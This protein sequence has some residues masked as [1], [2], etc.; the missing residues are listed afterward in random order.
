MAIQLFSSL[1]AIIA[2]IIG[3]FG[4]SEGTSVSF[5]GGHY[6]QL[7]PLGEQAAFTV[8]FN[9]RSLQD[10]GVLLI[11]TMK[12]STDYVA[13]V[14]HSGSQLQ[15]LLSQ[16]GHISTLDSVNSTMDFSE[17][18]SFELRLVN[19]TLSTIVQDLLIATHTFA[20]SIEVDSVYF[21]G[22]ES[23]FAHQF[24]EFPLLRYH[25]G[26]MANVTLTSRPLQLDVAGLPGLGAGCC[27]APRYPVW[28]LDTPHTNLTLTFP[29]VTP[30]ADV[31]AMSFRLRLLSAEDG[32]VMLSHTL[33]S[34]W[35]LQ[36]LQGRLQLSVN[37]SGSLHTGYC[38]DSML[39]DSAEWRQVEV[40]LSSARIT[41]SVD[42]L[43]ESTSIFPSLL[44][45]SLFPRLLQLGG[46]SEHVNGRGFV[47]CFQRPRVNGVDIAM[48]L[49]ESGEGTIQPLNIHWNDLSFSTTDLVVTEGSTELLSSSVWIQLPRD[50]FTDD[51]TALYQL[52][53]EN[54]IH[55]EVFL[56]PNYGHVYIGQRAA[57]VESF[58]YR[59]ILSDEPSLQVAYSHDNPD[60][61]TDVVVFRVWAGCEGVVFQEL[62]S[63]FF[64]NVEERD[65][66]LR[67]QHLN[68]LRLAVGTRNVIT[69]DTVTIE[70]QET[71]DPALVV[72]RVQS[73]S[74]LG[75]ECSL[76]VAD[77]CT[78]C[79]EGEEAGEVLMNGVSVKFFHQDDINRGVV[80]FQHFESYSIAPLVIRL[81]VSIEGSTDGM[82]DV[83]IP[84]TLYQGHINLTSNPSSDC[85]F[86]KEDG[87]ALISPKHLSV[88]TNFED[89]HPVI[90][91]D[92]LTL[93]KYGI[94]Q[95]YEAEESEW[96]D[97]TSNSTNLHMQPF[98]GESLPTFFTQ[99]DVND[100]H[101]RYVHSETVSFNDPETFQFRVRS[102]NFSSN[103]TAHLCVNIIP[104]DILFQPSI[105]VHLT[106]LALA[107]GASAQINRTVFNTSLD[108]EGFMYLVVQPE[109]SLQQLD[110]TY[111]L[112]EPPS[113][114][115]LE[116]Q[117][118]ILVAGDVF[119]H[120]DVTSSALVYFHGG[121][122]DHEDQ[123][124]FYGETG[125][126]E[127]LAIRP[128]N[129]TTN[130]TLV[131]DITPVNDHPPV[132]DVNMESIRP[133]E[134]CWVQVTVANINVTD[135]DRPADKLKIFLRK[136]ATT[137]TGIFAFREEPD[138]AIA[139]FYMQ[140]ILDQR[141]IFAHQLNS[142]LNYTQVLR[143]DDTVH[144]IRKPILIAAVPLILE[145]SLSLP[146]DS[147]CFA[148][149][150]A[151]T[152]NLQVRFDS[153]EFTATLCDEFG[154]N[155]E[156]VPA[157]TVTIIVFPAHGRITSPDNATVS[158]FQFHDLSSL[159]YV[160]E[161]QNE[162]GDVLELEFTH[163]HSV[164]VRHTLRICIQPVL[165][166]LG[167]RIIALQVMQ[168][169]IA[170]ITAQHLAV[171]SSRE[172][173]KD[174]LV[175]HV[176]R[177]P[178]YGALLN[179]RSGDPTR[180]L[181]QFT[182]G[183]LTRLNIVYD[184]TSSVLHRQDDI[185]VRVCSPF[186]C[187]PN[188][189]LP[190]GIYSTNL[191]VQ[192]STIHV[193]EGGTYRFQKSDFNVS[194]PP[195]YDINI[196]INEDK[197]PMYGS[198]F[199]QTPF[200]NSSAS[201]FG[202]EDIGK[203]RYS[204]DILENLLD[205]VEISVEAEG[206]G[207]LKFILW[208]VI[209][210][211]NHH[212]PEVVNPIQNLTV[213]QGGTVLINASI[214]SAHD[215]DAGSED[216]DLLWSTLFYSRSGYLFLDTDPGNA[217]QGVRNWKE[218]DVRTNRLYYRNTNSIF[219]YDILV[220]QVSD[221]G[222]NT[223]FQLLILIV[224][225]D[226]RRYPSS[227]FRL[228][229]GGQKRI[230][231]DYLRY[232]TVNDDSL[233][234][235]DFLLTLQHLPAHGQLTLDGV[236]LLPRH[237]FTQEQINSS[238]LL[239]THDH[240]NSIMDSFT[241]IISVPA[242]Q[243][244]SKQETFDIGIDAVDDDPPVAE[245]PARMFVVE[246]QRAEIDNTTFRISD[247]DS[248]TRVASD[249]VVCQ[250]VQPLIHGRLEKLRLGLHIN[251]TE[252]FTKYDLEDGKVWYR[253][254]GLLDQ[255]PDQL[256]FNLTDGI[257]KQPTV[258]NMTIIILPRVVS[259][260][261]SALTVI[262]NKIAVITYEEIM[263][264]HPYLSTV[265][266]IFRIEGSGPIH[267]RLVDTSPES[268]DN[269][270]HSFT[271]Q[272][273]RNK[274]I[275]YY[276]NGDESLRDSFQFVYE[277]LEPPE[278]NRRSDVETFYIDI[279]PVNDQHPVIHGNASLKLW[280]TETVL[281]D[282]NYINI[283]DYDTPPSKLVIIFQ[284][285]TIG[286]YIA[287]ANNTAASIQWFTQADVRARSIRF[288]HVDGPIG[289]IL[290]NVTD[291]EHTESSAIP[292]YADTLALECLTHQWDSIHVDFLG[293]VMV[294]SANL[295]CTTSDGL[296]NRE[297][298]YRI[299]RV[300]LGHFEVNS[301]VRSEFNSTEVSAGAVTFVHTET[302]LWMERERLLVSASS[303]PASP[304][305]GLPLFVEVRYPR[306]PLG[307]QLA[308]NT[309]LNLTEGGNAVIDQSRLDGRNLR[310]AAWMT[311]QSNPPPNIPQTGPP[312]PEDLVVLYQV[313]Q[314]PRHGNLTLGGIRVASFTQRDLASAHLRYT[315]DDSETLTDVV[316]FNVTV[317]L[318]EGVVILH[319]NLETIRIAVVPVNDQPPILQASAL[320][321]SLV[322]N[323]V[324]VLTSLDIE[325]TDD[326]NGPDQVQL[327][328]LS[329]PNNTQI[330]LNGSVLTVNSTITQHYIT[331]Q[332]ISLN[333]FAVGVGSFTF[334]FTDGELASEVDVEFM[335]TVE[336]HFL[337]LVHS[338]EIVSFQN[339]TSGTIIDSNHLD[340]RTNG[341]RHETVFTIVEAPCCGRVM[342]GGMEVNKFT[343]EDIDHAM[344]SYIPGS[345]THEDL[346][347]LNISNHNHSLSVNV[348]IHIV[349][350]GHTNS[351]TDIIE[352]GLDSDPLVQV[353]P[354]GVLLLDELKAF[355]SSIPTIK[356]LQTPTYGHLEMRVPLPEVSG[357]GKRATD[358]ISEFRYDELQQGWIVYVWDYSKEVSGDVVTD[359]FEVLVRAKGVLPGRAVITI[360]LYPP[361]SI[362]LT[363]D[364]GHS[365]S[366]SDMG[367]LSTEQHTS[368]ENENG[369]PVYTLVPI[370]GI[371]LFLLLLI[372]VVVAF[373]LTQQ[374][375]I[376]KKW[377][378]TISPHHHHHP[379]WSTSSPPIPTQVAHYDFDP[380]GMP[381][382]ENE[383]HNS[384]TS[385]GFSEPD[386]SP[387]HT[388]IH[389]VH[390]L[391]PS[392][393]YHPP[394]S[395]MRSNVS[396]TFSSR[397][398]TVSEETSMDGDFHSSLSQY[399][400]QT[401]AAVILPTRP[402]S[403]TAFSSRPLPDS[404]MVSPCTL[405]GSFA[406]KEVR[407]DEGKT[408][409][410]DQS[411]RD[412]DN[413][414]AEW[415][416]GKALPDFNDPN[417]QRLFHAHNPV[418]KKEEY[419]V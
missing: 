148:T 230:S 157:I 280:A 389:S 363:P 257:N 119:A 271:T 361:S 315:H 179:E 323:F 356:L 335:L 382:G 301:Q 79:D 413:A 374:K 262:E 139:Q 154:N 78:S 277:A 240:S 7:L 82:L 61:N 359:S 319:R 412:D 308:V 304:E 67:I 95:R 183:D 325:V 404:G 241:F 235:S 268:Q 222:K 215:F 339:E 28:C 312:T 269:Q 202:L 100:G 231:F 57:R 317:Q 239:Y 275:S 151:D 204:N 233:H 252:N 299:P 170:H 102:Y 409:D 68:G 72:F 33:T 403:H 105:S 16:G 384:D 322:K 254:L 137:P 260:H 227:S 247:F 50:E 405:E 348:S 168:G 46:S 3:T 330:L 12:N 107:E 4:L 300:Q 196:V 207:N 226:L 245:I 8:Q 372:V 26:C 192:N 128:P 23:F 261:L 397:H 346:F 135:I 416:E 73:V 109:L 144:T 104:Y 132:L 228:V 190:I 364:L 147:Q 108:Q 126:V 13:V 91:F 43:T 366:F 198:L 209:D 258:Y 164:P 253:H 392:P 309:G 145:V 173:E 272:D 122:E 130:L 39:A 347:S 365:T 83:T 302:G 188:Q 36:L 354:P 390:P 24:S 418:L 44:S 136:K 111:T 318:P 250:L 314:S 11:G 217:L 408:I 232:Y 177:G 387:R 114:G 367:A 53:L 368:S 283:T 56:G 48:S 131:I 324:T 58:D 377:V 298:T 293:V 103:I 29:P 289:R 221:G 155:A 208:I 37:M 124:S 351:K 273:I 41:C 150:D 282:E 123:F 214:F 328:L 285:Q 333:P 184:Y 54:V 30:A 172:E 398:S 40:S 329:L 93:P 391:C 85:V 326:D 212:A 242:R 75:S 152:Q 287:F 178:R 296:N 311:L 169:G 10:S 52:E 125:S 84:V 237:Y 182:H 166:P 115:R 376:K 203:L 66:S 255:Q 99:A 249:R 337:R 350:L 106:S 219:K 220:L 86:V 419:W 18:K 90:T 243:N 205:S 197:L 158:Q 288:V 388:P 118:E 141:V 199:I 332:W 349:A 176:V 294:T 295:R 336:D 223:T 195:G 32:L 213:V 274:S 371:I 15:V 34:V 411:H 386:C 162:T 117:G 362:P 138:R 380:S 97:L 133:P 310:Y 140:D 149:I 201:Y 369:F 101:V 400:P 334:K 76:C 236:S 234:D 407:G 229:E 19:N 276:H 394:R 345:E 402:S 167:M 92:L 186:S 96:V 370:I 42:G 357:V 120:R 77:D 210:P 267:G 290:Y 343:Q 88:S 159:V 216:E 180:P 291:G 259:L 417:I 146:Q 307:S 156:L 306:P 331:Q 406:R 20:A 69:P 87:L 415:T 360:T 47:G 321:K 64:I 6:R 373:C 303:H 21:G 143:I 175:F 9:F 191:T 94:L 297:I 35:S 378:P 142:S 49:V 153:I 116:L 320:Q 121:T 70:D 163:G 383:H 25:V 185:V 286:G 358:E 206:L 395:R 225:V 63:T 174:S 1:L 181:L 161:A 399:P 81:G 414:F 281:I 396:I 327:F 263:V 305:S 194:A 401:S 2:G 375:R 352:F 292:I 112:V 341:Y 129:R 218:R 45:T 344:V 256:V 55:F 385:S 279:I 38:P 60:N 113:F 270:I 31:L 338:Q 62:F 193:R 14:F 110:V 313:V 316:V 246:L 410:A 171:T 17:W 264:N 355:T 22:P 165:A 224:V 340:T 248:R 80:S 200:S 278:Y 27:V 160:L 134:G 5:Y 187:L 211:V 342:S 379:P 238:E 244:G 98:G 284:V 89:Q 189:T 393:S 127:Y 71:S 74:L 65:A 51:L 266:G 265:A 353:L 59:N 381:G 251:H